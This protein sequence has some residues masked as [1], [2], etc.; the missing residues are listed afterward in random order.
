MTKTRI[1]AFARPR[2]TSA[3]VATLLLAGIAG[4]S[5]SAKAGA[6]LDHIV[7]AEQDFNIPR[8]MLLAV[9]LVE[10]GGGGEPAAY[11][12]NVRGRATIGKTES[13][14]VRHLRDHKGKIQDAAYAGCMQLS[15]EHHKKSFQPVEKIVN[16]EANVRYAAR[17]LI[18]LRNETGSWAAAVARYNGA[19]SPKV[20]Q[21]YQCKIQRQL[22]SLGSDSANLIDARRCPNETPVVT[23]RTRRAFEQSQTP[24]G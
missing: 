10:T 15:V 9:S 19:S 1:S 11:A 6:C 23:P 18:Q 14:A 2:R 3:L 24:V 5:S 8:G 20:A 12:V 22:V 13:D 21:A 16:P 4:F 17:Y 7:K